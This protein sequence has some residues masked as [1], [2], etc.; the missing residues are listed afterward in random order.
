LNKEPVSRAFSVEKS[1]I[2]GFVCSSIE[3][4]NTEQ[5]YGKKYRNEERCSLF[6]GE[7]GSS[8]GI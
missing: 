2:S 3:K 7:K 8:F 1:P 4:F 6:C 5:G